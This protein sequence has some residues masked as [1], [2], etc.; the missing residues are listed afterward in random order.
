MLCDLLDVEILT[1]EYLNS[2]GNFKKQ[3]N[4]QFISAEGSNGFMVE[5]VD[6]YMFVRHFNV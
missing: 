2:E 3:H 1:A 5:F 6:M 4:S